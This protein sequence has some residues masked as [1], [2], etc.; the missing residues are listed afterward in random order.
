MID[1][2]IDAKSLK[3]GYRCPSRLGKQEIIRS[4]Y[5]PAVRAADARQIEKLQGI[6]ICGNGLTLSS[7]EEIV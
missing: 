4:K 2:V 7:V 3:R 6:E 5:T 1:P